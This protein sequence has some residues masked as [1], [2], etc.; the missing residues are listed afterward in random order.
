MERDI[1]KSIRHT[2]LL[3]MRYRIAFSPLYGYPSDT[4]SR[5]RE[6]FRSDIEV[7]VSRNGRF[8]I[9]SVPGISHLIAR[10]FGGGGHPHASGGAF[11]F[12]LMD[13]IAF[14]LFK[15]NHHFEDFVEI[16]E[17]IGE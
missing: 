4:A 13:R 1:Q 15:K 3:G 9:R 10:R 16:A 2:K 14:V 11:P 17:S 6:T 5:V 7:I 12:T 8:S